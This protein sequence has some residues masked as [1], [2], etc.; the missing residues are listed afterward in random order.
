MK[1]EFVRKMKINNKIINIVLLYIVHIILWTFVLNRLNSSLLYF[2][3]GCIMAIV[4]GDILER[5]DK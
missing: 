2:I 3:W 4:Y 1:C 5:N